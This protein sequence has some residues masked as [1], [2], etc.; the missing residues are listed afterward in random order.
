MEKL[1]METLEGEVKVMNITNKTKS[2]ITIKTN[3]NEKG[4]IDVE[5]LENV[6][7][8]KLC[9]VNEMEIRIASNTGM[10]IEY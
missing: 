7:T 8:S 2:D 3:K 1:T 5:I 10:R 9:D 4:E 6:D